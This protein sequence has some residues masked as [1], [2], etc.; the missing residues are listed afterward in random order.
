MNQDHFVDLP[1]Y[2]QHI[3]ERRAW[4]AA[5]PSDPPECIHCGAAIVRG[6]ELT[7]G[8]WA[9]GHSVFKDGD[10]LCFFCCDRLNLIWKGRLT[11]FS[12]LY[13]NA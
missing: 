9:R 8:I 7:E 2:I 1:T 13:G 11:R 12:D 6:R 10:R 4:I 3:S 5:N